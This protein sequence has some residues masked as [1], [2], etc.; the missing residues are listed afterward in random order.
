MDF[1][2]YDLILL[3]IFVVF[4]SIFLYTHRKNLK[5]EGLLFVYRT[6]IGVKIIDRIGNKYKRLLNVLGYVSIILGFLLM[7]GMLY[8]FGRVVWIYVSNQYVV[9]MIGLPPIM[10]LIPYIDKIAPSLN[11][12]NF[13]FIYW[14]VIIAIIAI[15]HEFSH[16]IFAANKKVK[17]KSTGFGF[18]PFFL[19]VFLAAFVELDEKKMEKKKILPQMAVLSAG[20]FA[21]L[22][23]TI[24]FFGVLV[25]FFSLAFAPAGVVF[26]SY[27]YS[28]VSIGS[29]YSVNGMYV[30]NITY[31]NLLSLANN[32]ELSKIRTTDGSTYWISENFLVKQGSSSQ[33][34]LLYND[35]PAIKANLS[36]IILRVNGVGVNSKEKLGIELLNYHPGDSVIITTLYEDSDRDYRITLGKN[37]SNSN[38]PYLGIGFSNMQGSGFMAEIMTKLSSFRTPNVYYK[39]NFGAAK[40]IYDLLLWLILISFSVALMNMLP[41]GIFDGG[42]FFYLAM[43]GLTKNKNTAKKIFQIVTYIFLALLVVIMIFWGISLFR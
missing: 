25:L 26:D 8:L 7:A 4:T 43:L 14:I 39:A 3:A 13:Y 36:N 6:K 23:T 29:I 31:T 34:V 42:R 21:N 37:P 15:T 17:I 28:A 18:F 19:P 16:G 38:N 2:I 35:A 41:V 30:N 9:K 27:V 24:L 12:P 11:L 20:T 32:T 33:Y 22:L 40:F 5:K 1:T 10:P